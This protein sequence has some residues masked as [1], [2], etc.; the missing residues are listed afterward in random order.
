MS[1]LVLLFLVLAAAPV[2]AQPSA[3]ALLRTWTENWEDAAQGLESVSFDETL[4]RTIEGPRGTLDIETRGTLRLF[5]SQRP[6]R[7]VMDAWV[8]EDPVELDKRSGMERRLRLSLGRPARYLTRP[9]PLPIV[10][11][12]SAEPIGEIEVVLDG[13]ER[14]WMLPLLRP[15]RRGPPERLTAWFSTSRTEPRL[16]RLQRDR[17][18]RHRDTLTRIAT[19]AR[20]DGLD[21]P[22]SQTV[23]AQIEQRRRLRT[24]TLV[25]RSEA[26]Y[27][28]PVFE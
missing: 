6:R 2:V 21:V 19:Y 15:S 11:L 3:D 12:D 7:T 16:L 17:R 28:A 26:T 24:Y 4:L 18:L 1:R 9:A 8:N 22:V 20:I 14:A 25:I 23:D 10:L 13:S 27:D 5:Q